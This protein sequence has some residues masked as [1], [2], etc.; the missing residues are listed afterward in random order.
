VRLRAAH[1]LLRMKRRVAAAHPASHREQKEREAS[2]AARIVFDAAVHLPLPST[3][4][5]SVFALSTRAR[6]PR[7]QTV[8]LRT[9]VLGCVGYV[10]MTT[11][12]RLLCDPRPRWKERKRAIGTSAV[13]E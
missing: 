4:V 5:E 11:T 3:P 1:V 13:Q 2:I 8:S 7:L 9:I 12:Y 10:P 6:I